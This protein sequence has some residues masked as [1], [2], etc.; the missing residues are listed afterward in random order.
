MSSED[1][2][3]RLDPYNYDNMAIY[4]IDKYE[5]E[6]EDLYKMYIMKDITLEQYQDGIEYLSSLEDFNV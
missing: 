4:Y 6:S 1:N 2:F 3:L 5:L